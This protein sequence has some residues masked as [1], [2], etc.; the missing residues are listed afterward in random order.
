MWSLNK[1]GRK[2]VR[3]G[4]F[5]NVSIWRSEKDKQHSTVKTLDSGIRAWIFSDS[6][7]EKWAKWRIANHKA[8]RKS[9]HI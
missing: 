5:R 4:I 7:S 9:E 6:S 2:P 3:G 8:V 1:T